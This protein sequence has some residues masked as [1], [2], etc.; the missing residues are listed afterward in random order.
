[1]RTPAAL[2]K[3]ARAILL[4]HCAEDRL[5]MSVLPGLHLM[6]CGWRSLPLV[7]KQGPCLAIVLQGTKSVEFGRKHLSYGAGQSLLASMDL[8]AA[9]RIASAS[10]THPLLAV[11]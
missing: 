2:W 9:S 7:A 10:R 8:P 4:R 1:M 11:A 5:S 6:R 3:E